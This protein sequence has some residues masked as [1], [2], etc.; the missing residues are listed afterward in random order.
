MPTLHPTFWFNTVTFSMTILVGCG[1]KERDGFGT[2]NTQNNTDGTDVRL[3]EGGVKTCSNPTLRQSTPLYRATDIGGLDT[4]D[5]FEL[6]SIPGLPSGEWGVAV[7]DFNDDQHLDVFIPRVG[8]NLLFVGDGKGNFTDVSAT[9]LGSCEDQFFCIGIGAIPV[10]FDGDKDLDIVLSRRFGGPALLE[11]DG[12]GN[13]RN[14]V[15]EEWGLNDPSIDEWYL[16]YGTAWADYDLDGDL[17]M[18]VGQFRDHTTFSDDVYETSA[19]P[20]SHPDR[21]LEN[22]GDEGF[23]LRED[24]LPT[25]T[26]D[27]YPFVTGWHD[28][29]QDGK[30][31]ILTA[32]D[33]GATNRSNRAWIQTDTGFVDRS[34]E[35]GFNVGL[36]AMGMGIG[37][38]NG[39]GQA[40][41]VFSGR[42][43]LV[44]IESFDGLYVQTGLSRELTVNDQQF[45]AWGL[46][47][48]DMDNDGDL[49]IYTT[50]SH[51]ELLP[52]FMGTED[53][54][55][56]QPDALYLLEDGKLIDKAAEW[57]VDDRGN[58][59]GFILA[60]FN[61]DGWLDILQRNVF[62]SSVLYLS[63]CGS[64]NWLN[65]SLR[66]L[67]TTNH[68]GI[69]AKITVTADGTAHTRWIQA[70]GHSLSSGGPLQAHFGLGNAQTID[71]IEVV[72]PNGSVST[73]DNIIG[74]QQVTIRKKPTN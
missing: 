4:H 26:N 59:R 29:N 23:V 21:L 38:I 50:F 66:D 47:M 24:L 17:D 45:Y 14:D 57:G 49:D 6:G 5:A 9:A 48:G 42:E 72:W 44:L 22:R 8:N 15:S 37:D 69:G 1:E 46:D 13:F 74:R 16:E 7:A 39:D 73:L 70:G 67:S 2:I 40:D 52:S 12:Y 41:F 56:E 55:K 31:D 62:D 51:W 30:P 20:T 10:D 63:N 35:L 19:Y 34:A 27:G 71:S 33:H 64:E 53:N 25:D 54:T 43:E 58:G 61:E 18:L 3:I 36:D 65:I 28:I 11:N 60:D 68:W 32:N